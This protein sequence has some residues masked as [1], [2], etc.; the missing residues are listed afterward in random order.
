MPSSPRDPA[1]DDV[2]PTAP[3]FT[4]YDKRHAITYA[5]LLDADAPGLGDPLLS[6]MTVYARFGNA[7]NRQYRIAMFKQTARDL[8]RRR[9]G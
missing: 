1:V 6:S 9:I 5:R 2:A 8:D 3:V 7:L 4:A